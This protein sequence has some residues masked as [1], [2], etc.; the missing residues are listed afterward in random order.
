VKLKCGF[1]APGDEQGEELTVIQIERQLW[2][3]DIL[4]HEVISDHAIPPATQILQLVAEEN[5][6]TVMSMSLK[7]VFNM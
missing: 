4:T 7:E 2:A 1:K 3:A 5:S 6:A